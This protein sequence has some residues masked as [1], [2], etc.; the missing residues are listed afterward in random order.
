MDLLQEFMTRDQIQ[1]EA[2]DTIVKHKRCTAALSM[3]VGK[4][5]I[6]L[7]YLDSIKN[8]TLYP[9]KVLIVAPKVSIY[10]SWMDDAVKFKLEHVLSSAT[11]STYIS[12]SKHDPANYDI[13]ILDECHSLLYTHQKFLTQYKGRILGLT[14]TPPRY[15]KS[16]KHVM[17]ASYCPVVY[18]YTTDTAVEDNILN[19]YRIFVHKLPL[20]TSSDIPVNMKGR[21]FFTSENQ[22]YAYWTKR[23]AAAPSKKMEQICAVMRMR[24][25]MDFKTKERYAEY[26]LKGIKDKCIIF[27][28]TQEQSD[29]LCPHSYH[30]GNQY[31][32]LHLAAFKKGTIKQLSCVAQLSEGVTIPDLKCG[33]IM[34]A[35]GNERKS[36]QR[37]GRMLRLN[38]DETAVVHILCYS[39]TKDEDWVEE[40]LKDLDPTKIT[41]HTIGVS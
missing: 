7:Q 10:K 27:C 1:K 25:L 2:L 28:N 40:A 24:V 29:R 3:G 32:D 36:N 41:Y 37:I 9:Y 18:T 12:L 20:S 17:V 31:S 19:D 30:S 26:L 6:G 22:S 35:F 4:T 5:L 23:L 15:K 21:N 13:V 38:P 16:E 8:D 14:G 39:G 11:F 33:I 34:H